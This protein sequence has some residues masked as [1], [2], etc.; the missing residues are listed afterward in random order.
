MQKVI[1]GLAF[2]FTMSVAK[3]MRKVSGNLV[4]VAGEGLVPGR[5]LG[6]KFVALVY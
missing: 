4:A 1:I 3:Y 5:D 6:G 2:S